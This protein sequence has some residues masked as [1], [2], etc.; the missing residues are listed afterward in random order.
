M[1]ELR[2]RLI[3]RLC[4]LPAERLPLVEGF[5]KQFEETAAPTTPAVTGGAATLAPPAA[6]HSPHA[7]L[8]RLSEHGTFIVTASTLDKVH[9]FRGPERLRLLE[10]EL[11]RLA[12]QFE[13]VLEAWAVFSN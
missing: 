9:H 5:L 4:R 12:K 10:E 7:P 1:D 11:L 6:Q 2:V 8:H 13:V 3:E